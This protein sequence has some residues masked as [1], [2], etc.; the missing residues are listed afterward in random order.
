MMSTP[1]PPNE[2]CSVWECDV[3]ANLPQHQ[4]K[5][6]SGRKDISSHKKKEKLKN[7]TKVKSQKQNL[8]KKLKN[9]I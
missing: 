6:S 3:T 8:N 2:E 5:S 7:L 1:N 4:K 9:V